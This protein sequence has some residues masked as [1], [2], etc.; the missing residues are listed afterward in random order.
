MVLGASSGMDKFGNEPDI[1]ENLRRDVSFCQH[2]GLTCEV[3][4]PFHHAQLSCGLK[5]GK[6]AAISLFSGCGAL[7]LG[8]SK[9]E[10]WV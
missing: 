7:E 5:A 3:V 4:Q 1:A 8:L 10:T 6:I 2:E 9:S